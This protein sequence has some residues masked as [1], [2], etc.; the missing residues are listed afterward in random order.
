MREVNQRWCVINPPGETL[1]AI[2]PLLMSMF[3]QAVRPLLDYHSGCGSVLVLRWSHRV[4]HEVAESTYLSYRPTAQARYNSL[5][6]YFTGDRPAGRSAAGETGEELVIYNLTNLSLSGKTKIINFLQ[7]QL[8]Q[9][10][11]I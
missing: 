7:N 4:L 5:A 3:H 6:N 10:F 8:P 2:P 9:Y 1:T 11:D